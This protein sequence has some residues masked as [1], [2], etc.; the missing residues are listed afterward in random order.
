MAVT[1]VSTNL[2]LPLIRLDMQPSCSMSLM[3]EGLYDV[4]STVR[5]NHDSENELRTVEIVA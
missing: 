2:F 1:T 3:L 5:P 4:L